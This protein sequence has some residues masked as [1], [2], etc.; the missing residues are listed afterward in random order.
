LFVVGDEFLL[1]VSMVVG[2]IGFMVCY[3]F[4][5]FEWVCF[6]VFGGVELICVFV[7]WLWF[8]WFDGEWFVEVVKV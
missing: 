4:E 2:W 5:F 3:D 1:V 8:F 6:V 7:N